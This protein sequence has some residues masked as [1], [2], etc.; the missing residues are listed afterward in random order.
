MSDV[1]I[2]DMVDAPIG[3]A[4]YGVAFR[5]ANVHH[6]IGAK[7][8][9]YAPHRIIVWTNVQRPNP[10][11]G[12]TRWTD[13]GSIGGDGK[14]LDPHNHGTDD[15]ITV[16][17]SAESTVIAGRSSTGSSESGQVFGIELHIGDHVLL[18]TPNGSELGPYVIEQKPLHDPHLTPIAKEAL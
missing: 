15:P 12:E 14:Y 16:T 9:R 7:H 17:T 13:F 3:D 2:I 8:N 4:R 18:R 6:I 11:P 10:H 1:K 5:G